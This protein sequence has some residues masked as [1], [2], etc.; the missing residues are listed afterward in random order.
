MQLG[1]ESRL[2]SIGFF[3]SSTGCVWDYSSTNAQMHK[4]SSVFGEHRD[5]RRSR[6]KLELGLHVYFLSLIPDYRMEK[7][8]NTNMLRFAESFL[9]WQHA[10]TSM[11]MSL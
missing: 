1:L 10:A 9:L 5:H 2:K 11:H 6:H 4:E 3:M 7:H 8:N